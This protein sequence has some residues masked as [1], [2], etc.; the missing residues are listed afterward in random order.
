MAPLPRTL[1]WFLASFMHITLNDITK[2]YNAPEGL[3]PYI[4]EEVFDPFEI[5]FSF[6]GT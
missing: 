2:L 3:E 6:G 4:I 1:S 5:T